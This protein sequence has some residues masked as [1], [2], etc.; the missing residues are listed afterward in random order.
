MVAECAEIQLFAF[1]PLSQRRMAGSAGE[2]P[3]KWSAFAVFSAVR[4]LLFID[5]CDAWVA[6]CREADFEV[7]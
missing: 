7:S 6:F 4:C 3:M 1:C 5:G 2:S